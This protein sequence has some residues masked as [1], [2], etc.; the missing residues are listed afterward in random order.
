MSD[1]CMSSSTCTAAPAARST[2][3]FT[4]PR[5]PSLRDVL[6]NWMHA[7]DEQRAIRHLS[8]YSPHLLSD[9]GF[10]PNMIYEADDVWMP[11]NPNVQR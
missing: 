3:A 9:M 1:I 7:G 2:R 4:W 6:G 11:L 10:E 5:R 8:H